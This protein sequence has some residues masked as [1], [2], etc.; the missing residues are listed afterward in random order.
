MNTS[1]C[2]ISFFWVPF[3]FLSEGSGVWLYRELV[4]HFLIISLACCHIM[5]KSFYK[6]LLLTWCFLWNSEAFSTFPINNWLIS[7]L[8]CARRPGRHVWDWV[9][10]MY[11]GQSIFLVISWTCM[12]VWTIL[13]HLVQIQWFQYARQFF[14]HIANQ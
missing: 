7:A 10:I 2:Q 14:L 1:I 12:N 13:Y 5:E 3:R 8:L 9:Y 4:G 11:S 6:P